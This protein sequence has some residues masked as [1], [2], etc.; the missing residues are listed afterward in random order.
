MEQFLSYLATQ[1]LFTVGIYYLG[2]WLSRTLNRKSPPGQERG[3]L[4]TLWV[5]V[6]YG[7]GAVVGALIG[8][9]DRQAMGESGGGLSGLG[10]IAGVLLGNVHAAVAVRSEPHTGD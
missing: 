8:F 4:V 6:L 5:T 2:R 7:L 9:G 3:R 1:T 10:L